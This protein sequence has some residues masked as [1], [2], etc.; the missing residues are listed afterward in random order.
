MSI[1]PLVVSTYCTVNSL[2]SRSFYSHLVVSHS[3]SLVP[4]L[5]A[6]M[7]LA[8]FMLLDVMYL[9]FSDIEGCVKLQLLMAT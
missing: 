3:L 8:I 2:S 1:N 4:E 9:P 6:S 5:F 7:R